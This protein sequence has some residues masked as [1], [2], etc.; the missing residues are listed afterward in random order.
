MDNCEVVG[1]CKDCG[2]TIMDC[3]PPVITADL[4]TPVLYCIDCRHRR[5]TAIHRYPATVVKPCACGERWI[6]TTDRTTRIHWCDDCR[7]F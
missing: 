3:R 6:E 1:T 7:P 4:G 2:T 5:W